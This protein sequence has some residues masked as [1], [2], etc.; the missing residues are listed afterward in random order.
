MNMGNAFAHTKELMSKSQKYIINGVG[1]LLL[2]AAVGAPAQAQTPPP[3]NESPPPQGKA[4]PLTK[5]APGCSNVP[6]RFKAQMLNAN[7]CQSDSSKVQ[8]SPKTDDPVTQATPAIGDCGIIYTYVTPAGTPG[9]ASVAIDIQSTDGDILSVGTWQNSLINN[10][11]G[12][13]DFVSGPT[14]NGRDDGLNF[15]DFYNVKTGAGNVG[16]IN[17]LTI[18]ETALGGYCIG[19]GAT[20]AENIP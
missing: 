14:A 13:V 19:F 17:T 3:G 10:N 8:S 7:I 5:I 2:L 15:S 16:T 12:Q 18:V 20:D 1:A 9:F 6:Q 4:Y 11:T